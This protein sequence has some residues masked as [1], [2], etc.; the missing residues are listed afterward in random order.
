MLQAYLARCLLLKVLLFTAFQ[1]FVGMAEEND[2]IEFPEPNAFVVIKQV[3]LVYICYQSETIV[4]TNSCHL[5]GSFDERT[6]YVAS[7]AF[8]NNSQ[9]I[10]VVLPGFSLKRHTPDFID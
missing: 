1:A 6:T 9:R 2:F 5:H 4:S 10:K 7:S 8:G 3:R